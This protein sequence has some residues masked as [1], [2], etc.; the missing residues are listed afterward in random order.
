[1]KKNNHSAMRNRTAQSLHLK[2]ILQ[3]T[4][5]KDLHKSVFVEYIGVVS[6][7]VRICDSGCR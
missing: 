6:V 5:E 7:C 3:F 1:M 4:D 2:N